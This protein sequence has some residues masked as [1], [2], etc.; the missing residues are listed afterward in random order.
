MLELFFAAVFL[1]DA[2][3]FGGGG[4]FAPSRRASERPIAMA[5]LGLVTFLPLRP[6]FSLPCF[7]SFIS[8]S[9]EAEAFGPYFLP[10]DFLA[11]AFFVLD[12]LALV[13]FLPDEL[14]F[15]VGIVLSSTE[16]EA[17]AAIK[18]AHGVFTTCILRS[19]KA[20]MKAQTRYL[21]MLTQRPSNE[22]GRA[23]YGW[24]KTSHSFS[25]ANYYDQTAIGFRALR[26]INEDYIAPGKGFGEHAHNDMEILTYVLEGAIEHRD[27]IGSGEVLRPGELQYMSAGTGIRHSEFNPSETDTLHLLQIWLL[28]VEQDLRPNY[29]QKLFRVREEKNR[30]HLLASSD[31]RDG[32]IQIQSDAELYA[33][34]VDA[35]AG[36]EHVFDGPRHGWLQVV[37][38]GVAANG[39]ALKA[40][41]GAAVSG[42]KS[43]TIAGQQD[44]EFLLFDLG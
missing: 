18:V 2:D 32:S 43:L 12:F 39:V 13:L 9:T 8:R 33:A 17:I 34:R 20:S 42:E 44:A 29:A 24:L 4:T 6:D 30:L 14:S 3:F 22:R 40:G 1:A 36:V 41:D 37:R 26:V 25:F 15:T 19:C 11:G 31:G 7:I 27:S 38:G 10:L 16:W 35:G 23:D 28:P 5:C 21:K